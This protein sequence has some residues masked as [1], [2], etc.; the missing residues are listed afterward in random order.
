M[1]KRNLQ[2]KRAL[3]SVLLVLL[4]SAVGMTNAFAA[5]NLSTNHDFT[6]VAANGQ[7]L[8]YKIT[9]TTNHTVMVTHPNAN[10]SHS[11]NLYYYNN[12]Y[13]KSYTGTYNSNGIYVYNPAEY[14]TKPSGNLII[15]YYVEYNG[16]SYSVTAID[17]YAFGTINGSSYACTGLTSVVIPASVQTIGKQAFAY[18]TGL[19]TV[20]IP[21]SVTSIGE[22]VF[23]YCSNLVTI[24][25]NATNCSSVGTSTWNGCTKFTTLNLGNTVT[26]IPDHGFQGAT[27]IASVTL[28]NSLTTIGISGFS[29]CTAL[30]TVTCGT[31][32]TLATIGNLAFDACSNLANINLPNT[33]TTI[34]NCAFYGCTRLKSTTATQLLPNA[35]TSI[36]DYAF[37]DATTLAYIRIPSTLTSLGKYAFKGCTALSTVDY[38]A[39]N[40]TSSGTQAEP[41]FFGCSTLATVKVSDNVTQIPAY[42][43]KDCTAL[44]NLTLRNGLTTIKTYSFYECRNINTLVLPVSVT[45]IASFAFGNAYDMQLTRVESHNTTPP[46]IG[47]TAAFPSGQSIYVPTASVSAYQS[48]TNWSSYN[49][50]GMDQ[51]Y[52]FSQTCSSGQTLYYIIENASMRTVKVTYAKHYNGYYFQ[53]HPEPSGGVVIPS[54]VSYN[55]QTYTVTAIDEYAFKDCVGMTAVTIPATIASISVAAFSGCTGLTT[56]NYNATNCTTMGSSASP[57][58]AGCT[59]LTTLNI[60]T[61][62]T[63][64]PAYAFKNCSHLNCNLVFPNSML[65][66]GEEAFYGCSSM[67]SQLNFPN[68]VTTIGDKAFYNCSSLIGNLRL[69]TAVTTVGASAFQGCTN[70]TTLTMYNALEQIGESA[71]R[72]CTGLGGTVTIPNSVL[73]IGNYAFKDCTGITGITL[74]T[75]IES[76]GNYAFENCTGLAVSIELPGSVTQVGSFAFKASGITGVTIPNTVTSMNTGA[77][78]LCTSLTQIDIQNNKIAASQFEAC[79][80]LTSITIPAN[81]TTMLENAFKNCTGLTSI[82]LQNHAIGVSAFEGCMGLTIVDIPDCITSI[83][84]KAF[85]G[86]TGL[87]AVSVPYTVTSLGTSIF[88]NCTALNAVTLHNSVIAESQFKGCTGMTEF[89]VPSQIISIG[90]SA[91]MNCSSLAVVNYNA[92]VCTSMGTS[93]NPVFGGSTAINTFYIGANVAAIANYAFK[94]CSSVAEIHAAPA[95]PSI[96]TGNDT[97]Y[98][99]SDISQSIPVY[100]PCGMASNYQN[101]TYWNHFSNYNEDYPYYVNVSSS[102]S[103]MGSAIVT[104]VPSCTNNGQAIVTATANADCFFVNWTHNGNVVSTNATY[105]FTPTENMHLI[106]NFADSQVIITAVADPVIG[107]TVTGGGTYNYGNTVTLTAMANT[108]YTFVNW[109]ENGD[110]VS[111]NTSISFTATANRNLVAHFDEF[112]NHWEPEAGSYADNMTFTCV[113]QLD[114]VEQRTTMYEVGAFCGTECRGSQR[115][116][117]FIPTDRYVIQMTVFG[118]VNDVISF[119]LY[120]HQQNE[121]LL[122]T[123]PATVTFIGDGYGSLFNPYVLNFTSTVLVS[124]ETNPVDAGSITGTGD[125]VVGAEVTLTANANTGYQFVNWT[126]NGEVVSTSASYQ[127]TVTDA[128]HFVA[129]FRNVHTQALSNGWNWW[130][131]FIELSNTDGLNQLEN[132]IGN[133]GIVIMSRINGYVEAYQYNS[134]IYWYGNLNSICNE[135]M[136]KVRT[137]AACNATIA[138]MATTPSSHPIN[139]KNGWNWI[140]FPCAQNVSVDVAMSS[141]TPENN[142][143][144]KGRN[145]YTTYYSDGNYN[146]WY[147]NLNTFEP[148]KGYMYRSNSTA[149]KTLVFQTGREQAEVANI[150]T[151]GNLFQPASEDFADNMT[152]T[153]VLEL[154]G[155][156]LRSADY[157]LAAFVGEECRG[158]VKLMYVEPIDRYVAFL[159][160]FGDQQETLQFRLTDGTQVGFSSEKMTYAVDGSIGT[161]KEP[162]VL[163]FGTLS[164]DESATANV[165]VYP[166]P[167]EGLFNIEGQGIRKVEVFN[168]FGQVILSKEMENDFLQIDLTQRPSGIYLFR[169]ITD[170]GVLNNQLI[171]K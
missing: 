34:G 54:T 66:I 157:E 143:I 126:L 156:E 112:V 108:N 164:V 41:P 110:V 4:L 127:F 99:F 45:S 104:Q 167:S 151:D 154:G 76:I 70:L 67:I 26:R 53:G 148:G 152:V 3:R 50:V 146:M 150:T 124:A 8:Y 111:T 106:A 90:E 133:S 33:L 48:A 162:A 153:A 118:E 122:L 18:C 61:G 27:K 17:E 44:T 37:Q 113:L 79:T 129:N 89:T 92:E 94:N 28:P 123:P 168:V 30:T 120:D 93:D 166:N 5:T 52:D 85:Y 72:G 36:G 13:L 121:E 95:T 130:S 128:T 46:T 163:H 155:E 64:I 145:N 51:H 134:S 7:T 42:C 40:C 11:S 56:V 135:Q 38:E 136:Y 55:G 25:F 87:T 142:D 169:I 117:Y 29:G 20:T 32:S 10:T 21:T 109:T 139:I 105:S 39:T 24:N 69:G 23:R 137:N 158:S 80:A 88:E 141:F 114:G 83:E 119:R 65:T 97:Q 47:A 147:G 63:T 100:V 73:Q 6:S 35:L 14:W 82:T 75:A 140:G 71:F 1:N 16:I 9:S 125:Y 60:G 31:A 165:M 170:D 149:Q 144:I 102:N 159:T 115:A 98:G 116:T 107:G 160:I 74:G 43:F 68:A 84:N 78:M 22:E 19:T 77:F 101:A 171:K 59:S 131:T 81:V 138:G 15:P 2:S 103:T 132:S 57:V 12:P 49:I 161:L 86:C 96:F 58:F 62:V 91:L